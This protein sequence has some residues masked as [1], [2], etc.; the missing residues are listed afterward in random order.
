MLPRLNEQEQIGGVTG[1]DP[2]FVR[3]PNIRGREAA[4]VK[5][6]MPRHFFHQILYTSGE[7][8]GGTSCSARARM[9]DCSVPA[10]DAPLRLP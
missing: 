3:E 2:G 1:S 5:T 7:V 6:S 10:P 9:R 4:C 8:P